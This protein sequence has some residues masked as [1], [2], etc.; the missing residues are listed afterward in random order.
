MVFEVR[1]RQKETN[2]LQ[3]DIEEL[4]RLLHLHRISS[5]VPKLV[6]VDDALFEQVKCQTAFHPC[7]PPI[8]AFFT[9]SYGVA[10]ACCPC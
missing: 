3:E 2:K 6:G 8:S 1:T 7:I 9:I 4:G 10:A 5:V